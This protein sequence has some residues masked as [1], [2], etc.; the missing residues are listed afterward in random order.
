MQRQK[1]T[2]DE[3]N[4]IQVE[5]RRELAQYKEREKTMGWSQV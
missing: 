1:G 3:L 4:A 5:L 2:I